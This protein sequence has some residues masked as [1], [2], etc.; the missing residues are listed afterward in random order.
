MRSRRKVVFIFLLLF[1]TLYSSTIYF[2]K[3]KLSYNFFDKVKSINSNDI[4]INTRTSTPTITFYAYNSSGDRFVTSLSEYKNGSFFTKLGLPKVEGKEIEL[5]SIRVR[6]SDKILSS[7]A[8]FIEIEDSDSNID[9]SK[10]DT[11][12]LTLQN[13]DD[14]EILKLQESSKNSGIFRGYFQPTK[15]EKRNFDGKI[16]IQENQNLEVSIDKLKVQLPVSGVLRSLQSYKTKDIWLQNISKVDEISSGEVLKN[17]IIVKNSSQNSVTSSFHIKLDKYMKFIKGSLKVDGNK[18]ISSGSLKDRS[19]ILNLPA[20]SQR[21]ISYKSRVGFVKDRK[22]LKQEISFLDNLLEIDTKIKDDFMSDNSFIVGKVGFGTKGIKGVKLYLENGISTITDANGRYH[23]EGIEPSFHVVKVDPTTI[24]SRFEITSCEQNIRFAGSKTIQ[25]VDTSASHIARADFCVKYVG[26]KGK[27]KSLKKREI[28]RAKKMPK[29]SK[30]SFSTKENKILWPPKDFIPPFPSVKLAFMHKS[31]LKYKVFINNK[32]VDK[33][34]YD[35]FEI[36]K[37]KSYKIEKYRGVTIS[38]GDNR[39]KIELLKGKKVVKVLEENIHFSTSP[40]RVEIVKELS[41]LKVDSTTPA[42]LAIKFF[43][44]D[45]YPVR[46]GMIGKCSINAPYYFYQ[47]GKSES[48]FFIRENKKYFV[49][50]GGIAYLKLKPTSI[51]GEIKLKFDFMRDDEYL[52]SWLSVNQNHWILVGFAKGSVGYKTIKNKMQNI[53]RKKSFKNLNGS[54]FAKGKV[55]GDTILTIAYNS[56][57][58]VDLTKL[59]NSNLKK[60][61]LVFV[62]KSKQQNEAPSSKKLYI[63]LE[64]RNFY[65]LFGDFKTGLDKTKLATYSVLTNGIKSKLQTKNIT[66]TA[67]ATNSKNIHIKDELTTDGTSGKYY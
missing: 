27:K 4:K 45:G 8:V 66:Y 1:S 46:E 32:E 53:T 26:K 31:D 7:D 58:K 24:E 41:D 35:G 5:N 61:Y 17:E 3:A 44:K 67:F 40:V 28:K 39:V 47:D 63:K 13:R 12:L 19:F 54:F 48:A 52:S 34:S 10:V 33:L 15:S 65:T 6:K 20:N 37:D 16:Y 18:T 25:F 2:P 11:I 59:E 9:K 62:D 36:S 43:D 50:D 42:V 29:Y 30:N 55:S 14:L 23:F 57:K 51:S 64:R 21:V 38:D 56:S 49:K 60:S 22:L